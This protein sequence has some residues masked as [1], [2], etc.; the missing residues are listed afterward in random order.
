[1]TPQGL[2]PPRGGPQGAS[3][4]TAPCAGTQNR[5][6]AISGAALPIEALWHDP[7]FPPPPKDVAK[8]RQRVAEALGL[9]ASD[10]TVAT[11]C[12]MTAAD[13][14][15][16]ITPARLFKHVSTALGRLRLGWK[17]VERWAGRRVVTDLWSAAFLETQGVGYGWDLAAT[18][19][20][21]AWASKDHEGAMAVVA[22]V[23]HMVMVGGCTE[24]EDMLPW[25]DWHRTGADRLTVNVADTACAL[26]EGQLVRL[27][28]EQWRPSRGGGTDHPQAVV[29]ATAA[30]GYTL[31]RSQRAIV[32]AA[33]KAAMVAYIHE[34]A[35]NRGDPRLKN[36]A[37]NLGRYLPQV[38][39]SNAAEERQ[40]VIAFRFLPGGHQPTKAELEQQ[41][42]EDA[43][44]EAREAEEAKNNPDALDWR[45]YVG[46]R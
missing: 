8:V 40:R 5:S 19:H 21:A 37:G 13:A 28:N 4:T 18:A 32:E 31:D 6:R 45:K 25:A 27:D 26:R 24:E 9:V 2:F 39:L 30:G 35:A 7:A 41:A 46:V 44:R 10:V 33:V 16:F 43:A 38:L 3:E 12:E 20:D 36:F 1:M 34:T 42:I 14:R 29:V 23:G 22:A 11:L 15:D 17:K